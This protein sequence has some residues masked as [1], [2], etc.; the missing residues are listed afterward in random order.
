MNKATYEM[1][2]IITDNCDEVL[3]FFQAVTVKSPRVIA[4]PLSLCAE[5]C[6]LV[7]FCRWSDTNLTMPTKTSPQYHTGLTGVLSDITTLL[8]TAESLRPIITAQHEAGK[9]IKG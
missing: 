9:Y 3:D 5:K 7:W 6:V 8:Q 4:A 1:L 2:A